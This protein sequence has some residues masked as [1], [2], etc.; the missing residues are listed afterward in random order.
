MKTFAANLCISLFCL[1]GPALYAQEIQHDFSTTLQKQWLDGNKN[2]VRKIAEARLLQNPDDLASQLILFEYAIEFMDTDTLKALIPR[3]RKT[4]DSIN[5]QNYSTHK[6]LLSATLDITES[7]LPTITPEVRASEIHKG[8]IK[9][10]PMTL[11]VLIQAL[12]AD[13]MVRPFSKD[14][15]AE[16]TSVASANPAQQERA[17]SHPDKKQTEPNDRP[18]QSP[19]P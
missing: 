11:A 3:I 9:G 2:G 4:S 6:E 1:L 17:A 15:R 18:K 7:I 5:S 13:K 19:S 12:E 16:L 14:E 10:K 8:Y